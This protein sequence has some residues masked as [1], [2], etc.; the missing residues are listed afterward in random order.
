M[1]K[2]GGH[3]IRT[4]GTITRTLPFQGSTIGHSVN[5]PFRS[6]DYSKVILLLQDDLL[7][8]PIKIAI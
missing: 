7:F 6:T 4:H 8:S 1:K 3:G 2:N 5:P